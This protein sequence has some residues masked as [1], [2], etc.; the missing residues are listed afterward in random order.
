[1]NLDIRARREIADVL[2]GAGFTASQ[3][4]EALRVIEGTELAP[5][6]KEPE[7]DIHELRARLAGKAAYHRD[8]AEAAQRT[9][10]ERA[11]TGTSASVVANLRGMQSAHEEAARDFETLAES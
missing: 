4:L 7:M 3:V 9:A 11:K 2:Y 10:D 1:M 8:C 5:P 6:T